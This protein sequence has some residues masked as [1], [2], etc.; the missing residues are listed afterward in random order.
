MSVSVYIREHA[1]GTAFVLR[2]EQHRK[3]KWK[4]LP[5]HV[6][7]VKA[8]PSKQ[9]YSKRNCCKGQRSRQEVDTIS[10]ATL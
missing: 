1:A 10:R 3:R 5:R 8:Q 6:L 7:N 9:S 2:D 4:T